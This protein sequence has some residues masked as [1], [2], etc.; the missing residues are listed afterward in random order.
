MGGKEAVVPRTKL[1]W[2]GPDRIVHARWIGTS[3][4]LRE[5]ICDADYDIAYREAMVVTTL[6]VSCLWCVA[7]MMR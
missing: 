6:P 4:G 1:R 7:R 5:T 2:H 3:L